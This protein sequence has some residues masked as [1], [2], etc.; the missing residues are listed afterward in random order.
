[1][2]AL[3]KVLDE[4]VGIE[5]NELLLKEFEDSRVRMDL[6]LLYLRKVHSF[7]YFTC[8]KYEN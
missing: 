4:E 1:M 6:F 7:D 5:N 3:I 8:S 2:G